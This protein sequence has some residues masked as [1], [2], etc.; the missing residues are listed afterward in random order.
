MEPH[1]QPRSSSRPYHH[2][3][4]TSSP[5]TQPKLPTPTFYF[6][7]TLLSTPSYPATMSKKKYK[8][9]PQSM[10][11]RASNFASSLAP[12]KSPTSDIKQKSLPP[13]P[14]AELAEAKRVAALSDE[15]RTIILLDDSE[16][17]PP[18]PPRDTLSTRVSLP[19]GSLTRSVTRVFVPRTA[20]TSSS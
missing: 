17:S 13:H 7:P 9:R 15:A 12:P 4:S 3:F 8:Q 10:A 5:P 16:I 20:T 6:C 19:A 18:R 11:R 1:L 14:P 2:I